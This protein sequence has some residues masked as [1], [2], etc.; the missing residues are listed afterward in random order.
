[1]WLDTMTKSEM[2][3]Q[4]C[5]LMDIGYEEK[6]RVKVFIECDPGMRDVFPACKIAHF[7]LAAAGEFQLE[8]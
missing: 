1:M 8:W 3:V 6:K 4:V 7:G 5:N 2:N